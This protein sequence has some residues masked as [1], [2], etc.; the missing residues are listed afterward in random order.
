MVEAGGRPSLRRR[1]G[2]LASRGLALR[3]A[4]SDVGLGGYRSWMAAARWRRAGELEAAA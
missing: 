2:R 1:H 4:A 3:V